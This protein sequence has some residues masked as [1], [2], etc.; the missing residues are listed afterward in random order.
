MLLWCCMYA[1]FPAHLKITQIS[2]MSVS[3]VDL[4]VYL[5]DC[6]WSVCQS[7]WPSHP[8]TDELFQDSH[9]KGHQK[10]NVITNHEVA[11]H[12]SC[13][14][15]LLL[16][17]GCA[18]DFPDRKI[19]EILCGKMLYRHTVGVQ[20]FETTRENAAWTLKICIKCYPAGFKN[21]LRMIQ[22]YCHKFDD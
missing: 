1:S 18:R 5:S 4:S 3:Q 16:S 6:L 14:Q 10:V 13:K 2:S 20:K 19:R 21:D 17:R 7:V 12:A 9:W 11:R 8:L 15:Q 22:I